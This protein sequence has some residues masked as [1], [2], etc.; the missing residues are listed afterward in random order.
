LDRASRNLSVHDFD[1]EE[2]DGGGDA[3]AKKK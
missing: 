3:G 2:N 1:T